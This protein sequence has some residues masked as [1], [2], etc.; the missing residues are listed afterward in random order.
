MTVDAGFHQ[1]GETPQARICPELLIGGQ[2]P[3]LARRAAPVARGRVQAVPDA[4]CNDADDG[5]QVHGL[6]AGVVEPALA[7]G[8]N[9]DRC[10]RL[11]V[12]IS[13]AGVGASTL[14][15]R[16]TPRLPVPAASG[17]VRAVGSWSSHRWV[18]VSCGWGTIHTA[19][20]GGSVKMRTPVVALTLPGKEATLPATS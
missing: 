1:R 15:L 13:V 7:Q 2:S 10:G 4:Q 20:Y 17:L 16:P 18:F 3:V 11:A 9:P 14:G 19:H 5:A 6:R 8:G 12:G